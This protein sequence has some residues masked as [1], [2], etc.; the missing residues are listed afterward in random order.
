M[1]RRPFKRLKPLKLPAGY[2]GRI[3][4]GLDIPASKKPRW[5]WE[6]EAFQRLLARLKAY[7]PKIAN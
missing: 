2:R 3:F 1:R 5:V 4:W 6:W 7:I